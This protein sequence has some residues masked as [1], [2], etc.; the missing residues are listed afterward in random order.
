MIIVDAITRLIPGVLGGESS[1]EKESYSK[2][3]VIEHPHYTRPEEY[4][5]LRVPDVLLSGH[6]AEIE[7]WRKENQK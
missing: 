5:G 3:A 6:H 7:N 1:A 2:P 4:R